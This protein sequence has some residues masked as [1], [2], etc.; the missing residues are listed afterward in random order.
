MTFSPPDRVV[1]GRLL[2]PVW[3]FGVG[4][5]S[6]AALPCSAVAQ[7]VSAPVI[8]QWFESSWDTIERRTADFHAAGYGGLW[9][10][11][12]GRAL[13]T[14]AGGGIGY[15]IYDRFDLGGPRDTTLNGTELGYRRVIREAQRTGS[16]VYVDYVHH[17]IGSFDLFPGNDPGPFVQ[18]RYDY[19]GFK[20]SLPGQE[21][22]DTYRN[23]PDSVQGDPAFEYQYRLA[24]L[25]TL[26]FTSS[27]THQFVRNP[28]PGFADNIPQAASAWAI[29]TATTDAN[30]RAVAS[31]ILRQANT[32]S[33]AN[34]R[35]YPDLDAPSRTVVDGG[36]A[37]TVHDFNPADPAAGDPVAEGADGAMM[38][39][40]QW[41]VQDL[42]L[43]GL[44][45]DAARH[46]PLGA[47]NDSFNPTRVDVPQLVD[48]AV[49]GASTRTNLDGTPRS[50][51][52]FQEV[53][54]GDPDFLQGFVRKSAAAGDTTDPD[55]DVLDFPMWFAMREHLSADGWRNNWYG[56][57]NASQDA[58]DDGL[59]NNGS[60]SIGFV[61]N[62][63]EGGLHLSNVAH[64]WILTRP[65]NA[66]VYFRGN[67]FDRTGNTQFFLKDGRGDA[68]G[69]L[70][71]SAVTDLV[72][73]RNAYGRGDFQERYIDGGGVSGFS[74]V[75]AYEREGSMLVGLSSDTTGSGATSFDER[76]MG[77]SFAPGTRLVELTGNA[78]N[79]EVDPLGQIPEL[80]TVGDGGSVTM[81]IPRNQS[82]TGTSHGRGY[83]MYG[84]PRPS[85]TLGISAVAA[86]IAGETP[87]AATNSS[88]RL[89][90]IDVVT[91]DQF[92][93]SLDTQKAVLGD[94]FHDSYADGASAVFRFNEGIDLNGNGVVDFASSSPAN[95]TRYGFENFTT[96]NAP[97][98]NL[99]PALSGA[100]SYAQ[101]IDATQL[102]E[103]Y[104]Y[105]TVRAF[106]HQGAGESEVFTDFRRTIY[107]DR[108]APEASLAG[109]EAINSSPDARDLLVRS[110]DLTADAVHVLWNLPAGLDD[111]AVLARVSA[112]NAAEQID[113]DLFS[114]Q[115]ADVMSGNLVATVVTYELT[116]NHSVRRIPGLA[117]AT[118]IGR[119]LGD[120]NFDAT[121]TAGDVEQFEPVVYSRD[122]EFNPAA[123]LNGDGL[124]NT[125]DMLGLRGVLTAGGA[126]GTV[127][128]AVTS[129]LGRRADLSGDFG[130]TAYDIDLHRGRVL[131]PATSPDLWTDDINADGQLDGADFTAL[132]TGL[133]EK[134]FGDL[135]LD[136]LVGE[137]DLETLVGNYGATGG[138]AAGNVTLDAAVTLGD[139][140]VLLA[141]YEGPG[142]VDL[143]GRP[144][145]DVAGVET[146]RGAGMLA[147]VGG[148]VVDV[149]LGVR[150]SQA[151]HPRIAVAESVTKTGAGTLV[152]DA[153]GGYMGSTTVSG[154]TLEV[155]AGEALA[156]SSGV[157]VGSGATLAV[158][159]G[160]TLRSPR[161]TLAGGMLS[162]GSVAVNPA[163]GIGALAINS[164][165]LAG[166]ASLLVG[167]GGL[168]ELPE[169][170]R[171]SV[172]VMG[173]TVDD[174][175]GGGRVDLGAGEF[176]I[177]PGG[178]TKAELVADIQAGRG[179]G[180]WNGTSGIKSSA[181]AS[182]NGS[183]TVGY[184]EDAN[185][186]FRVS[187][188]SAGDTN[189]DGVVDLLDLLA[190]LGSGVYESSVASD[191]SQGDFNYDGVT[192]L[193]D[194]LAILGSGTYD[195]GSY[196]AAAPVS[197]AGFSPAAVPEPGTWLL[198]ACGLAGLLAAR[199]R[200]TAS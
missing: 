80:V 106:R 66:Y 107:V 40:A 177:A 21:D 94:G 5:F 141:N 191:W 160:T 48:R 143:G 134:R 172:S 38:R 59:A 17:H 173:L 95:T 182:S 25:V 130:P 55:R 14:E 1:R 9:T 67:D 37:Y 39:Y 68:L 140:Q 139:L 162:G 41:L 183:R 159:A 69:G 152:L 158:A 170:A 113:R 6:A 125:A 116:G 147:T 78:A 100:G 45:V 180:S 161:V 166:G 33:E 120:L 43:D 52:Q 97:G 49:A 124:V 19:P 92:T 18:D 23:P 118:S 193:L 128:A 62:H 165:G 148:V 109:F 44:R 16:N 64:A 102:A 22:G 115:A 101:A 13:F 50:V 81:R 96:V 42:G 61:V 86:M 132:V 129:M 32:P 90:E 156:G 188:A 12:P 29:P 114:F 108:L 138:W 181:A 184:L 110:D 111:A 2:G 192:D 34:R 133:F 65:G 91:A 135:D 31:T 10:P 163:T 46:V 121:F 73:I 175:V 20:L 83:V 154:G 190:V 15:D 88:A 36:V 144:N 3:F 28:V 123:D 87:T 54:N 168:V 27:N 98:F 72:E 186:G 26:N 198:A 35:F 117:A 122:A 99:D 179:D 30:G 57:R 151:A 131:N 199:R 127:Q 63:D 103:G 189:L 136:G 171:V 47:A 79:P 11:P 169:E 174:A 187:Y 146:L 76:T 176:R 137:N 164:G 149:G 53:F 56:I 185:G 93:L 157:T 71:G 24:R 197:S 194:L 70:Y 84:L 200:L 75:Y 4:L 153:A 89:A 145:L 82:V 155:V 126:S 58:R 85:G 112:A 150:N 178:M 74:N 104:H 7:N 196:F 142:G 119:G 60:Q 8:L 51:F 77:S 195:Q 167:P 105:L